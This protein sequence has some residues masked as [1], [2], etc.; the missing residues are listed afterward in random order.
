M[1][2][3]SGFVVKVAAARVAAQAAAATAE[4]GRGVGSSL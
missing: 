3:G 4:A 1:V 2:T